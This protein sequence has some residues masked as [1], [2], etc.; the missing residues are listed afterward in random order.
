MAAQRVAQPSMQLSGILMSKLKQI[1][2]KTRR[3]LKLSPSFFGAK[4]L[5]IS[6]NLMKFVKLAIA[7][8]NYLHFIEIPAKFHENFNEKCQI[9]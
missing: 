6:R 1:K 3:K 4:D 8:S 2:T 9:F 7:S 5:K